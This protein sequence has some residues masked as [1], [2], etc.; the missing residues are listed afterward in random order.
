VKSVPSFGER[1]ASVVEHKK[2]DYRFLVALLPD[3]TKSRLLTI[4]LPNGWL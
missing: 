4:K 2:L 1:L 3:Q